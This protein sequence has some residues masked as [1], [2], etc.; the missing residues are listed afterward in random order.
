MLKSETIEISSLNWFNWFSYLFCLFP[1][2]TYSMEQ[3]TFFLKN[4]AFENENVQNW[5]CNNFLFYLELRL[6]DNQSNRIDQVLLMKK[7][8]TT[9]GYCSIFPILPISIIEITYIKGRISW[10]INQPKLDSLPQTFS[11][12][13]LLYLAW[14]LFD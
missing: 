5:I 9:Q 4:I 6:K 14:L 3:Y 7:N 12:K 1:S 8:R 2:R 10:T 11:K 13:L